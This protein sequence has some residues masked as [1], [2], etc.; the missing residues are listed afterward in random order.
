MIPRFADH[1]IV[2]VDFLDTAEVREVDHA[3]DTARRV[4]VVD[5][6]AD[7]PGYS[8]YRDTLDDELH[9]QGFTQED[10]GRANSATVAVRAR[11]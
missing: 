10:E 7:P 4:F 5:G 9:R 3:V 2:P 6:G 1:C 8:R 11:A